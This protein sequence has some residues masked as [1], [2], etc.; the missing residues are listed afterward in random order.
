M[1]KRGP[2]IY[3]PPQYLERKMKNFAWCVRDKVNSYYGYDRIK[4]DRFDQLEDGDI[5]ITMI[6]MDKAGA[7]LYVKYNHERD[8]VD[9]TVKAIIDG[10]VP[11]ATADWDK[12]EETIRPEDR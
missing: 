11:E 3:L 9:N 2:T 10:D 6:D 8:T 5:L 7:V 1:T 12:V 4:L